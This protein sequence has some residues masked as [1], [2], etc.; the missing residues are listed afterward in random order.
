MAGV[1][2]EYVPLGEHESGAGFVILKKQG[3]QKS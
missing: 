2:H 3:R 1:Y